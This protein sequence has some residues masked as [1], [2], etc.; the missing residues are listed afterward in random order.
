[1]AQ[2]VTAQSFLISEIPCLRWSNKKENSTRKKRF[3]KAYEIEVTFADGTVVKDVMDYLD[4]GAGRD[5][6]KLRELPMV[7]KWFHE[8]T[9][10]RYASLHP[11]ELQGYRQA[12]GSPMA[13]YLPAVYATRKQ[14]VQDASQQRTE[15]DC[16]LS[17]FVGDTLRQVLARGNLTAAD[18]RRLFVKLL[19]TASAFASADISWGHDFHSGNICYQTTRK[20]WML[21]DLETMEKFPGL[22]TSEV[23]KAGKRLRDDLKNE[24]GPAFQEFRSCLENLMIIQTA[25]YDQFDGIDVARIAGKL[26]VDLDSLEARRAMLWK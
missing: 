12:S 4:S 13:R 21:V 1:M 17:E 10:P 26:Q 7:L 3:E 16:L 19:V 14:Y 2:N 18:V 11:G 8:T 5:C 24:A 15:V 20:V 25:G 23:N 9:D 22:K 6:Y